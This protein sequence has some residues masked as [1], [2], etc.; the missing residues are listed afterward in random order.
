MSFFSNLS[1]MLGGI[2]T[3]K[4]DSG[5][6]NWMQA[7]SSWLDAGSTF[8]DV[9]TFVPGDV[10]L[11]NWTYFGTSAN[12]P[13]VLQN[14]GTIYGPSGSAVTANFV[15][16]GGVAPGTGRLAAV[17][18]FPP[19][20]TGIDVEIRA[21]LPTGVV[22]STLYLEVRTL[23]GTLIASG[24]V[25]LTNVMRTY[26]PIVQAT[27]GWPTEYVVSCYVNQAPSSVQAQAIVESI[28]IRP[29]IFATSQWA[30]NLQRI[31]LSPAWLQ[32]GYD[33]FVKSR[34]WTR[35]SYTRTLFQTDAPFF[36]IE[37]FC[38]SAGANGCPVK[39][40]G[41]AYPTLFRSTG[42]SA[43][44]HWDYPQIIL[45]GFGTRNIV[46]VDSGPEQQGPGGAQPYNAVGTF[47]T[48]IYVPQGYSFQALDRVN[49]REGF[50]IYGDSIPLG[51]GVTD[52]EFSGIA[53]NLRHILPYDVICDCIG[54][55]SLVID[56]LGVGNY[57]YLAKL[58]TKSRPK[59]LWIQVGTNDY[60]G[61][62]GGTGP[63]A[64]WQ[65][66]LRNLLIT[67]QSF[68]PDITIFVQTLTSRLFEG[69]NASGDTAADYRTAATN[70]AAGLAYC[71][72]VDASG[73]I[74]VATQTADGLH[75]NQIGQAI[76]VEKVLSI[77]TTAEAA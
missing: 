48:A 2:V 68:V 73:W 35:Q 74:T 1:D 43:T 36:Y 11:A 69:A 53:Q 57:T 76:Y 5:L 25:A 12:A 45:S 24:T 38:N 32:T 23:G 70:A 19:G 72:V 77:L 26:V 3:R 39:V 47:P 55:R 62:G 27:V 64:A 15:N 59:Y 66:L 4:V 44:P 10:S 17:K 33:T 51:I 34:Y 18:S 50:S 60:G 56:C 37:Q 22:S 58:L 20:V 9:N 16:P 75:L 65:A 21:A 6:F 42:S 49:Q 28:A 8:A 52:P 71:Q 41:Q 29:S 13:T 14:A 61:A 40:N 46:E 67:C 54:A 31:E 7:V 63:V 30:T